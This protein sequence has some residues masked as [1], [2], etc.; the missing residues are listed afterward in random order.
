MA[1]YT[2]FRTAVGG[3]R[4]EDVVNFIESSSLENRKKLR[5]LQDANERLSAEKDAAE[6]AL[7]KARQE[8]EEA[9]AQLKD[10]QEELQT[11]KELFEE[12]SAA[13]QPEAESETQEACAP[14]EVQTPDYAGQELAAYRRAAATEQ[15]AA[16]RA[17]RIR[18]Q[19]SAICDSARTRYADSEEEISAL[20]EDLSAGLSRLQDAL[21]DLQAIFSDAEA[22]FDELE[23]PQAD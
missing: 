14:A 3:F 15:N 7:L 4:R 1:D 11:Y 17:R 19:L 22:S 23:L 6:Q 13:P 21:A 18:E 5:E 2:K 8:L 16:Q 10:L 9:N 20:R 12:Q